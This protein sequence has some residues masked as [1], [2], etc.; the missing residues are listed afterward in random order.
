MCR[1]C[2][3]CPVT[4]HWLTITR[5]DRRRESHYATL[6]G[7][8]AVVLGCAMVYVAGNGNA[9]LWIVRKSTTALTLSCANKK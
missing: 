7:L 3:D 4:A 6:Y 1:L 8:M 2:D 5:E 9:E